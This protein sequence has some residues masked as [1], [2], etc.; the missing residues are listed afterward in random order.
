[1]A[2]EVGYLP[3]GEDSYVEDSYVEDLPVE[4]DSYVENSCVEDL[5]VENDS[6]VEDLPVENAVPSPAQIRS[7]KGI[8]DN[9]DD[10]R[11]SHMIGLAHQ[12]A[13]T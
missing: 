1:M 8:D 13:T 5:P 4:N 10:Q 3:E 7:F 2:H 9:A 12:P 11:S 6:Y